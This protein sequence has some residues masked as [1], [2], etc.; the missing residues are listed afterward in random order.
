MARFFIDRPIFAMVI[1][2][3]MVLAGVLS[4]LSLPISQYPDIAPPTVKVSTAYPGANAETVNEAVTT[5]LDSQINGVSDMRYIKSVSG[6]D[7]SAAVTVTFKL[8]RDA[9]I[10]AV[11]TQNRVSQVEPRLPAEVNSIGVTVG[12]ASPDTL[13]YIALSSP[14]D[15]YSSDVL[16]NYVFSYLI[17]PLKRTVGIGNVQVFGS[18]YGMR[19]WLRPDRLAA[20]GMT[21]T[22]VIGAI[23]DQNQQAAGR[24]GQPPGGVDSGF[25]FSLSASG[26]LVSEEEFA[27]IILRANP[28]GSF[29]RL[30]DV[31]RIE[32][33]A[34]DYGFNSKLDGHDATAIG[35]SLSPG[36]NALE[37]AEAVKTLL[38]DL[39]E[40]F[41]P[42]LDYTI[43]YDNSVFVEASIE[44]VVSTFVE[45]L[46]LVLIVVFLF[47]QNWRSTIIPMLAVPVS[48]LA[49]FISY[50]FL[51]FS[52]NTL[53]LFALVLAIGIVVDDAIVVV[54]AVEQKMSEL[55]LGVKEATRASMDE[56]TAPIVATSIVLC[57]IFVPMSLVPGVVGQLYKQFAITIAVSVFFST[58]VALTLTPALC[59]VLLRPHQ[60]RGDGIVDRFFAA[61]ERQFTRITNGYV[62]LAAIGVG[63]PRRVLVALLILC[64][65]LVGL[66]RIT[67]TGFVPDEDTG[68]FF[69]S[70]ALPEAATLARTESVVDDYVQ[71][72][73]AMEGVDAVLSITGYD[74]ISG[75]AG[76]ERRAH[77]HAPAAL[78]RAD[79]PGNAGRRAR[80][81]G[82]HR[83][84]PLPGSQCLCIQ[85]AGPARIR[86]GFG[87]LDDDAGAVRA[88]AG[89]T[90]RYG[91]QLHC[92]GVT[93]ARNRPYK[94][95]PRYVHA[96]L[97]DRGRSREGE[98]ARC[99]DQRRVRHAADHARQLSGQR[100]HPL[101]QELSRCA[102]G[103]RPLSQ[104]HRGP[105][106]AIR[107]RCERRHG[108]REHAGEGH[109]GYGTSLHAAL[110]P[111]SGGRAYGDAR[112][113]LFVRSGDGGDHGGCS[114]LA[115]CGLR[116]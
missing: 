3:L 48:L 52:I 86:G 84:L 49:T 35:I 23:Q 18:E 39:R 28:D 19:V 36:A 82:D 50:Q 6:D 85:S 101:R 54:E 78:G 31:A 99:S 11:E 55:G 5:P 12:K 70:V 88:D 107:P 79:H 41:P 74:I 15:R 2:L 29:L 26:R 76:V 98:E 42:G 56:V 40:A 58:I 14:D 112:P 34:K 69:A 105:V 61:F 108:A 7:G 66:A 71:T 89:G 16:T 22:D 103:R 109:A 37:S 17:D 62:S 1:S 8:E 83:Q 60:A 87:L 111:L 20:F 30:G 113:G 95:Q 77:H 102:A 24:V 115:A 90:R 64:V 73:G 21:P 46:I 51:G 93:A 72:L 33:G 13:L 104:Q 65:G 43:V 80:S 100:L 116:L 53:S 106:G 81:Q 47:L 68:A 91:A 96:E 38:E 32:L 63:A 94:Y 59:G 114:S 57:A 10:A 44:E 92:S 45:A 97:R 75:T 27:N 4:L 9:D 25:T 110:Q 67:P